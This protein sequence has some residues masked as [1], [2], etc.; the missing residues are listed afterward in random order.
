MAKTVKNR[1]D[2]R[3][4]ARNGTNG[5]R[6]RREAET[7]EKGS[8]RG[9]NSTKRLKT[10]P[11]ARGGWERPP[12][13]ADGQGPGTTKETCLGGWE[14]LKKTVKKRHREAEVA[15][16]AAK[17]TERHKRAKTGPGV[18]DGP[19]VPRRPQTRAQV[20]QTAQTG[21]DDDGRPRRVKTAPRVGETAQ[22]G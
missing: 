11:G 14:R 16:P 13:G 22:N 5:C 4:R 3:P 18:A 2:V 19:A 1:Q 6:R 21:A 20:H 15:R 8:A 9:R 7:D 17:G 12:K 10:A